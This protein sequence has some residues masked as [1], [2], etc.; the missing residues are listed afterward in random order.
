MRALIGRV[1]ARLARWI[2]LTV[3]CA[4]GCGLALPARSSGLGAPARVTRD[5]ECPVCRRP[6][7][8]VC[9]VRHFPAC[10]VLGQVR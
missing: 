2:F 9:T 5:F 8:G 10:V 3:P 4:G 7:C 6:F 1:W